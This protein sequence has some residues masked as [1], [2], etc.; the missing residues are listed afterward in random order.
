[1]HLARG[2]GKAVAARTEGAAEAG[3]CEE[4][5]GRGRCHAWGGGEAVAARMVGR[6]RNTKGSNHDYT[7]KSR[8]AKW[9]VLSP[10]TT[11]AQK[12]SE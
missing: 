10:H 2:G 9:G 8:S 1:M 6:P 12:Q 7:N 4:G 11:G 5:Q 3:G